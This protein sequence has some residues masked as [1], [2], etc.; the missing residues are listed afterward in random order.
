VA[1]LLAVVLGAAIASHPTPATA[2]AGT[3]AAA[4]ELRWA[5]HVTLAA[6]W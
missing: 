1:V 2:Q 4:G 6:R 5:L 3:Q